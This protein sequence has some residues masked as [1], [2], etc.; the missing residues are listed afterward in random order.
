[1]K[2]G[3]VLGVEPV[4]RIEGQEVHLSSFRKHRRLVQNEPT[5]VNAGLESHAYRIPQARRGSG[6]A[7]EVTVRDAGSAGVSPA[8]SRHWAEG[9]TFSKNGGKV[10][11][12]TAETLYGRRDP[13][14]CGPARRRRSQVKTVSLKRWE[15]RTPATAR[16]WVG[17]KYYPCQ[18][19]P[20]HQQKY[21]RGACGA[22]APRIQLSGYSVSGTSSSG[23]GG[24][25][26]AG[27][28][29]RRV[30]RGAM[31]NSTSFSLWPPKWTFRA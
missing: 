22:H 2:S 13:G 14:E 19:T 18:R 1:M 27:W 25:G 26:S 12:Q 29:R 28:R 16:P 11:V 17:R 24:G 31:P 8:S 9:P 6:P 10:G 15:G 20:V 5:I 7:I 3:A 4:V 30:R 23:V 21:S